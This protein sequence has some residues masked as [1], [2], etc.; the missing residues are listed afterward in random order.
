MSAVQALDRRRQLRVTPLHR[1]IG[2]VFEE[3]SAVV[4]SARVCNL[5]REGAELFCC[6]PLP[7]GRRVRLHLIDLDTGQRDTWSG[8]ITHCL[9]NDM[10]GW[11]I[12]L[13]LD[14][15]FTENELAELVGMPV[16]R[17]VG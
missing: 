7:P 9:L 4:W 10:T 12:G 16:R 17:A 2:L 13:R 5:C 11:A 8:Q 6:C 1:L 15:A 3:G 14:R